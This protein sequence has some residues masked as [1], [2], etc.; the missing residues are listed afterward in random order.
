M[1]LPSYKAAIQWKRFFRRNQHVPPL[2]LHAADSDR[3]TVP[4]L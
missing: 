4:G 1:V 3:P 2:E